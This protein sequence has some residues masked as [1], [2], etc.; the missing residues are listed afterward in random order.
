MKL[1]ELKRLN[2]GELS[3]LIL[4]P[5]FYCVNRVCETGCAGAPALAVL[6]PSPPAGRRPTPGPLTWVWKIHKISNAARDWM[7]TGNT[8]GLFTPLPPSLPLFPRDAAAS[9]GHGVMGQGSLAR[10]HTHSYICYICYT[11]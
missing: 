10:T 8:S 6:L 1:A 4:R 11:T 9:T 5:R 3:H 7:T 2:S